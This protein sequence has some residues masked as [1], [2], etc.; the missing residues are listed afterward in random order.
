MHY[1]IP[2]HMQPAYKE[3]KTGSLPVTEKVV[4]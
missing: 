1:P 4:K 3:F 2:I